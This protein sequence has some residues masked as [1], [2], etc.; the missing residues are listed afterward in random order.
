MFNRDDFMTVSEIAAEF[1]VSTDAVLRWINKKYLHPSQVEVHGGKYYVNKEEVQ[2]WK[3]AL[4]GR[5]PMRGRKLPP[6]YPE[7]FLSRAEIE[8]KKRKSEAES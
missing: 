4:D 3:N 1:N 2:Q 5:P 8:R 7:G 6:V